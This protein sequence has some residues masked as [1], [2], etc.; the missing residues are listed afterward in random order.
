M[1]SDEWSIV[2]LAAG[3]AGIVG[4]AGIVAGA[5]LRKRSL[6]WGAAMVALVGV[7]GFVA[8]LIATARAM[9]LSSHDFHVVLLVSAAAGV[10]SLSFALVAAEFVVRSARTLRREARRLA[11]DGKDDDVLVV[12]GPAELADVADELRRTH[13]RLAESRERERALEASRRELVA[14]VSHDLRTPLA[15]LRAMTEALEDGIADD[16]DRYHAR[17]RLEVERVTRM[18]DDLFE[19]SCIH[20]GAL[21]L[22]PE[23]VWLRDIVSDVLAGAAP[24]ARTRGV[25]L[26]G[27]VDEDT[28]VTADPRELSRAVTNLV[29]NAI[30]HTPSDG[31]VEVTGRATPDDVELAVNDECGGISDGDLRRVF[32]VAWRGS[33]A[34][35][36]DPA[37]PTP[38][39]GLGLA[40]VRGIVEAH[41]GS[42]DVSNAGHGC[43]FLVRLPG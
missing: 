1:T 24:V 22:S 4:A 23:P 36:P 41:H 34:R 19:L 12:S 18:V 10:V 27:A 20:A 31:T 3:W 35:T 43:R 2:G 37:G 6:R 21:P 28:V 16:P 33:D 11:S 15:G 30:R 13:A 29:M 5:L 25:R 9:F 42:V 26:G 7:G 17:M 14:W 8:A 39:A 32:D 40:I 38:G